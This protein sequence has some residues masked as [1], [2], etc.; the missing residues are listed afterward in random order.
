MLISYQ[1][2]SCESLVGAVEEWQQLLLLDQLAQLHPLVL[3]GIHAYRDEKPAI[4]TLPANRR[5]TNGGGAIW[6]IYCLVTPL[7][8]DAKRHVAK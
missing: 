5:S 2:T 6:R 7:V 1:V 4:R 8:S 3:G